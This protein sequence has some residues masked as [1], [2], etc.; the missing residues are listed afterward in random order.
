MRMESAA[1]T[2]RKPLIS[3]PSPHYSNPHSNPDSLDDKPIIPSILSESRITSLRSL[4]QLEPLGSLRPDHGQ[5]QR[6]RL[7]QLSVNGVR[8]GRRCRSR[9]LDLLHSPN[10]PRATM[11]SLVY[12]RSLRGKRNKLRRFDVQTRWSC[13]SSHQSGRPVKPK[14]SQTS[15]SISSS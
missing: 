7:V 15:R 3:P 10:H 8:L 13:N 11:I 14:R 4:T 12:H 2:H 9:M 1:K 6:R 5:T